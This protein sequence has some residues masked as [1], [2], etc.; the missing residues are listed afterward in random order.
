M[1]ALDNGILNVLAENRCANTSMYHYFGIREYSQMFHN[2]REQLRSIWV[3]NPSEKIIVLR[4][5]YQR[6]HSAINY[7]NKTGFYQKFH[8]MN[9]EKREQH[10][11]FWHHRQI[12][13]RDMTYDEF[14]FVDIR[15]H[16]LPYL[17]HLIGKNFR[18]INFNRIGE[19]LNVHQ[20]PITNTTETNF[21]IDFL[22]FFDIDTLKFE[23]FLYQEYLHRF[24]EIS[25]EEWKAK[26][27]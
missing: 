3:Q 23:K 19:Y 17:R 7:H 11:L 18:Y 21:S 20:G 27:K 13:E 16:C 10:E 9:P 1:F 24:E 14:R 8:S 25:P 5:P 2:T 15:A 26:T 12:L 4:D 6:C 22:D